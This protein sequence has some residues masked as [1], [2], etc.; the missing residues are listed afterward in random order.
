MTARSSD[1]AANLLGHLKWQK[2]KDKKVLKTLLKSNN[3][4]NKFLIEGD[5][6]I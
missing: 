3:I 5:L 4:L 1:P 2:T 6:D